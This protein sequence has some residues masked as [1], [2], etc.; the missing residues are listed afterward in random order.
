MNSHV[1]WNDIRTE[2]VARAGGEDAVEAGKREGLA[3]V[4]GH[5]LAEVRRARGLTEGLT[6]GRARS[7]TG[8]AHAPTPAPAQLAGARTNLGPPDAGIPDRKRATPLL[9]TTL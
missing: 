1:A 3:A 9:M 4:I 8:P 6:P 7:R 2:H 5:R